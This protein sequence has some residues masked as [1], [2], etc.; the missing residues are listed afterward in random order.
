MNNPRRGQLVKVPLAEMIEAVYVA[1]TAQS[2]FRNLVA[3]V[4]V[5]YG[6][7]NTPIV[8]SSLAERPMY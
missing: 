2:W 1:P 3:A 4:T 7:S 6:F 5:K 8:S